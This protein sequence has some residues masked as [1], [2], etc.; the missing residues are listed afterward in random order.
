[1]IK[2]T[3]V[4][5]DGIGPEVTFA[6]K[7]VIESTGVDIEWEIINAGED[8]YKSTGQF[9]PDELLESIERNKLVL[10]GPITTPIGTGF[11]SINVTLRQKYNT[12]ANVRPIKTIPN[13]DVPFENV[14]MVI[15]R[16]NTEDLYAG[17]ENRISNDM[18]QSIKIITR[19]ASTKIG[20]YAF[21]YAKSN[22]RKKVTA[23]HKANIMKIS[24]GLFLECIR[25][26]SKKYPE[27]EYEEVIVDNMCMQLVMNPQKY[28]V[29]VLPNL[30]G[31][32]I[33]DLGAGLIGGLGLVPG[34]NIGDNI[35]IFESVHGSA[36]DIAGRNIANPIA[37]ILSGAMMLDYIGE[38]KAASDIRNAVFSVISKE[39]YLTKDLGGNSTTEEITLQICKEL[40]QF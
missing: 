24:D 37:C 6:A 13:I 16:E 17:I 8:V 7:K 23:V 19:E 40:K 14:D 35:G 3:L 28:D 29:L 21:E 34:A 5:G 15:I 30:Y 4:P 22:N 31:D 11:K 38:K 36:P 26:V 25:D 1:M 33:S 2:A 39:D 12:F 27:I 32:I 10:K 9:I 18:A 20:E